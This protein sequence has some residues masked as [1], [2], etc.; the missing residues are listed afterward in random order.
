MLTDLTS[1]WIGA[2][3]LPGLLLQSIAAPFAAVTLMALITEEITVREIP[4]IASLVHIT[5]TVGSAVGLALV[6]TFTRKQEQLHSALIGQHIE[7]GQVAVQ[8]RLDASAAALQAQG[9]D[10]AAASAKATAMLAGV[11][12][13]EAFV[14][15]YADMFLVLG[16]MIAAM[17]AVTL[18]MYR[19]KLPGKFL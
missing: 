1:Q 3:L 11:V 17:A 7:S 8:A 9:V 18:F 5:R 13:R 16:V 6:A 19:P 15:A 10:P 12:Q 14:L 2:Q 4:W